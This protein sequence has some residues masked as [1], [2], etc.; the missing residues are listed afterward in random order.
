MTNTNLLDGK[1][2]LEIRWHGR[3]GQGAKTAAMLFAETAIEE[4]KYGQGF[5]DYGP[6]R[7]GAPLKGFTRVS[8]Q[9]IIIHS[10]IEEPHV[11]VVLDQ[12]LLNSVNIVEGVP[13]DGFIIVNTH[14]K[15][16]EIREKLKIS[17][18]KIYA[19]NAT[20]IALDTIG[21]PIPNTVMLGALIKVTGI[22]DIHGMEKNITK[23]FNLKFGEKI[24]TGNV[25]AIK[26]A[27]EE[28]AAE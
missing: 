2:M 26:K 10:S 16:K 14:L 3:G 23:K 22:F 18:R 21:K 17:D 19:V 20:Q 1:E 28:V 24:A 25:K 9:P 11:V 15:P 8:N 13:S 12:T 6:E 5:P 27:F 7:M 4:G